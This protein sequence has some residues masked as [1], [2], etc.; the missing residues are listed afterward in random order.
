M[1]LETG[2]NSPVFSLHSCR[3]VW[4]Y[5]KLR[6]YF[7]QNYAPHFIFHILHH[8]DQLMLIDTLARETYVCCS[9]WWIQLPPNEIL[10]SFLPVLFCLGQRFECLWA[11]CWE[12]WLHTEIFHKFF[13]TQ[14]HF[15]YC[16]PC[17]QCKGTPLM[18]DSLMLHRHTRSIV[19]CTIYWSIFSWL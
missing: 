18:Y 1:V 5:W 19:Q 8:V 14:E 10:W 3:L 7:T 11:E 13:V 17:C 4:F 2:W 9:S 12:K 15:T 6:Y 16:V